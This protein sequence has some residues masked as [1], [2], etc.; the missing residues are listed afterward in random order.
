M[1]ENGDY[2]PILGI[3]LGFEL[4]TYVAAN[5]A[6]HRIDCSSINQ[7][8]PLEFKPNFQHSVM[9]GN[10]P[11]DVIE[12]LRGAN[13]TANYH[14]YC[15]TEKGLAQVGLSNEFHVLS[16]N[17]D[18][19]GVRFISSLEHTSFPFYG[20]QFHPEKNIYE[21]DARKKIPHGRKSTRVAQ[22]FADFFVNQA[23]RNRHRFPSTNEEALSLIYNYPVTYTGLKKSSFVQCYM[24]K[25]N[26]TVIAGQ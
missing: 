5:R 4:L 16:L 2:F 7:P 13:V 23:R 21:W 8:L 20:V 25:S 12:I 10:A 1:N 24:F 3:C 15:V 17:N 9:F 22:Y 14:Q 11:T 19:N 26:G 6:E 18:V